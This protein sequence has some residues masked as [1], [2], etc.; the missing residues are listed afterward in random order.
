[1]FDIGGTV[2]DGDTT[3]ILDLVQTFGTWVIF[4][5]LF[6]QERK[7]HEMTR[8]E[9]REDLRSIAGLRAQLLNQRENTDK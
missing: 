7:A 6:V 2:M 8:R 5:Y 3:I 4:V 9:Y 1:M